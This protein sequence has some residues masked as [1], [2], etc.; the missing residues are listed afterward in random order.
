MKM[1]MSENENENW[2]KM[3]IKET[4]MLRWR[5]NQ[6]EDSMRDE[7]EDLLSQQMNHIDPSKHGSR[8]LFH[9]PLDG[10]SVGWLA[11]PKGHRFLAP[12][13]QG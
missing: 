9:Q 5:L 8:W 2:L 10:G 1:E 3:K 4:E 13:G 12:V 7:A 11:P 6:D